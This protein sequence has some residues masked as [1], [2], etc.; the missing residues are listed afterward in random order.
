MR[1][2]ISYD[3]AV[4][5]RCLYPSANTKPTSC[6]DI[7]WHYLPRTLMET[8]S[9][10][11]FSAKPAVEGCQAKWRS[12]EFQNRS[13]IL[14]NSPRKCCVMRKS[15]FK[16]SLT[17]QTPVLIIR[18]CQNIQY[19]ILF[20]NSFLMNITLY[21]TMMI[22][23]VPAAQWDT[24]CYRRKKDLDLKTTCKMM[25]VALI[26]CFKDSGLQSRL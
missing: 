8:L 18:L 4:C 22:S 1:R 9:A 24:S 10:S 21:F 13:K 7:L 16:M 15:N 2:E 6:L 11:L 3:I 14:I 25:T 12:T 5:A 23:L 17:V 26:V 19:S 20:M